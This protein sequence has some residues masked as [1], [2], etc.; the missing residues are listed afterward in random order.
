MLW[1]HLG[2]HVADNMHD[3]AVAFHRHH[4]RHAHA[5]ILGDAAQVVAA[6]VHQHDMLSQLLGVGQQLG[7]QGGVLLLGLPAPARARNRVQVGEA[8]LQ[9]H[10]HLRAGTDDAQGFAADPGHALKIKKEH[11]RRRVEHTQ[12][13]VDRK[14]VGFSLA[15]EAL[16]EH[17]L[18]DVAGGDKLLGLSHHR[19]I[20]RLRAVAD[21]CCTAGE[22]ASDR[23][24]QW[25]AQIGD[26][27]VDARHGIGVGGAQVRLH[28]H[29]GDHG[30]AMAHVV[31]NDQVIGKEQH[32]VGQV[33]L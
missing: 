22:F 8:I 24:C 28:T 23:R 30:Q 20:L 11:V 25:L 3:M 1:A 18:E 26:D 10:M 4:H 19:F 13:A 31:K 2:A 5:A 12:R 29:V 33:Q 17:Y 27:L 14:W 32:H 7:G 16:A 6:Q 15:A 9:P 21:P